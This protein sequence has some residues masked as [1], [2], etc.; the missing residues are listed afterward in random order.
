MGTNTTER[1]F[2][3]NPESPLF[4]QYLERLEFENRVAEVFQAFAAKV[5]MDTETAFRPYPDQLGIIPIGK[6]AETFE[7]YFTKTKRGDGLCL[8]RKKSIINSQWQD[9]CQKAGLEFVSKPSP[10]WVLGWL[11][12]KT[13]R[14]FPYNGILY[15]SVELPLGAKQDAL[16]GLTEIK[17]S[18]FWRVIEEIEEAQANEPE[19]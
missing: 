15:L 11:E 13:Y 1:F 16:P 6:D 2:T 8:F 4:R 5:G 12:I 3:V 7:P 17:G 18:E 10:A 9:A 14:L 19:D